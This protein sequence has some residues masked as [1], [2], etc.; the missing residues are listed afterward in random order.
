MNSR[1]SFALILRFGLV[2]P[3]ES[4]LALP[5]VIKRVNYNSK[6]EMTHRLGF[7]A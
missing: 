5:V 7:V 4:K 3:I 1:T 2:L 6:R